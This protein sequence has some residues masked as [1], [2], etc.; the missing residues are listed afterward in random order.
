MFSATASNASRRFVFAG[1]GEGALRWYIDGAPCD[2]D[3]AGLPVWQPEQSGFYEVSA[4]DEAG[5]S[6]SV[7]VS[8]IGREAG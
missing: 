8:V 5:R 3:A 7:R 4:V 6:A 2:V 1:R